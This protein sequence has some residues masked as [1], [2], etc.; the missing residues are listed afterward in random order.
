[1]QQ[2]I[3]QVLDFSFWGDTIAASIFLCVIDLFRLLLSSW[4]SLDAYMFLV[5]CS[6]LLDFTIHLSIGSQRSP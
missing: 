5:V 3:N 2:R 4:L 1:M 6:F